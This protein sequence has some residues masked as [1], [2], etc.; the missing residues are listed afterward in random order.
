M[1]F[2]RILKTG[3]VSGAIYG[4]LQGIV[5]VL[6]YVF[7]RQDIID[8]IRAS[9]PSGVDIPMTMDQL[10]DIGMITAI[11]GS[12]IGGIIAGIIVAFIFSL[13]HEDLWGKNDK[14]KGVF[15]CVL[16]TIA[17]LLGEALY[18]NGIVAGLFMVQTR[19]LMLTP[20][21]VAFFIFSGYLTGMFYERFGGGK[22]KK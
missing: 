3:A 8:L 6:S 16:L 21:S 13:M 18:P 14:I 12:I 9:I 4:V 1:D 15:L 20:L 5:S 2:S 19:F 10:A 17:I 7:Y 11:P 22:R